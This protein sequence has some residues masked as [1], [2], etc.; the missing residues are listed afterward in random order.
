ML[1]DKSHHCQLIYSKY[2]RLL[3]FLWYGRGSHT[4]WYFRVT[5]LRV[6]EPLIYIL[7][8]SNVTKIIKFATAVSS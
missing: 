7:R 3:L 5:H 1:F 6:W 4:V 8:V 2:H